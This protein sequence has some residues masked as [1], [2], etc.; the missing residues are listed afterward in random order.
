[1]VALNNLEKLKNKVKEYSQIEEKES[2]ELL[3]KLMNQDTVTAKDL[4]PEIFLREELYP[5]MFVLSYPAEIQLAYT[6]ENS[7]LIIDIG[8]LCNYND[9]KFIYGGLTIPDVID[10]YEKDRAILLVSELDVKEIKDEKLIEDYIEFFEYCIDNKIPSIFRLNELLH[11]HSKID[12]NKVEETYRKS[13]DLLYKNL[14]KIQELSKNYFTDKNCQ[15]WWIDEFIFVSAFDLVRVWSFNRTKYEDIVNIIKN[16]Y[17]LQGNYLVH[18]TCK[19]LVNKYVNS[20]GGYPTFVPVELINY[21]KLKEKVLSPTSIAIEMKECNRTHMQGQLRMLKGEVAKYLTSPIVLESPNDLDEAKNEKY[22]KEILKE[23]NKIQKCCK[24][25]SIEICENKDFESV[26][27][28]T[29]RKIENHV[30]EYYKKAKD[31]ESEKI[32]TD[33]F[34]VEQLLVLGPIMHKVG[35]KGVV[36]LTI[37][38][39]MESAFDEPRNPNSNAIGVVEST[40]KDV[41]DRKLKVQIKETKI[42]P[43]FRNYSAKDRVL[44]KWW[45]DKAWVAFML[46]H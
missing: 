5:V 19:Y 35:Q 13:L 2:R 27:E 36:E 44:W 45:S 22:N 43:V 17:L 25:M 39:K 20:L 24:H 28:N 8:F 15:N 3:N 41:L 33:N 38:K 42:E 4:F 6:N 21:K 46:R 30:K 1:M 9:F 18:L 12:R 11:L 29:A 31:L 32:E 23:R 37:G 10:L 34:I 26:V 16:G 40:P 7:P 14:G